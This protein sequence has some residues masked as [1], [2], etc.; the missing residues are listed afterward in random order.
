MTQSTPVGARGKTRAHDKTE[1]GNELFKHWVR[2]A[3]RSP[4]RGRKE[5]DSFGRK[6]RLFPW[7]PLRAALR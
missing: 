1:D 2:K 3:W 7:R 4:K 5:I 6:I